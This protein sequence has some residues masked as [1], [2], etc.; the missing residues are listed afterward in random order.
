MRIPTT[1][2]VASSVE[3]YAQAFSIRIGANKSLHRPR[4][5]AISMAFLGL[6]QQQAERS[7]GRSSIGRRFAAGFRHVRRR[8]SSPVRRN[9]WDP[10]FTRSRRG[11]RR[12]SSRRT[13]G[14]RFLGRQ[15]RRGGRGLVR[16]PIAWLPASLLAPTAPKLR[17]R[18]VRGRRHQVV[19]L[20]FKRGLRARRE[21]VAAAR[22]TAMNPAVLDAFALAITGPG[23]AGFSRCTG[24]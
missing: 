11:D 18:A 14:Q 7:G 23:T 19:S 15:P 17:G 20:H 5:V 4:H 8:K 16:L 3:F 2:V 21:A 12:R 10:A 24:P 22:D 13:G 1:P 9:S 6:D